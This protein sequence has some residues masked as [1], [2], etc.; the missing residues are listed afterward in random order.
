MSDDVLVKVALRRRDVFRNLRKYLEVVKRVVLKLDPDGKVFLFGSV[1]E[2]EYNYSSDIDVL[3]IT[4]VCPAKVHSELWR[5]GIKDP[6]EVHV[7]PPERLNFY[8]R[9][10]FLVKV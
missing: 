9:R 3:I 6:F 10:V 8:K 1:A 7:H 5:A 4:R 2:K